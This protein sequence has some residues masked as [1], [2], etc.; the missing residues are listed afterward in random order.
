[1]GMTQ[2]FFVSCPWWP[3]PLTFD[4]DLRTRAIFLYSVPN[5]QVW[6]SY[7][8]SFWSYR[9]DKHTDKHTHWQTNKQTNRRRWKHPPCF[10]TLRRWLMK[11]R[12]IRRKYISRTYWSSVLLRRTVDQ[13]T[14]RQAVADVITTPAYSGRP[15]SHSITSWLHACCIY[16]N[17]TWAFIQFML[18]F[19][20]ALS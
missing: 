20:F 18:C 1:M 9:A 2:Q 12:E 10:A 17:F 8:Y 16:R 13:I 19:Y 11:K 3:W 6:S 5:R 4:L 15:N 14:P 7:V